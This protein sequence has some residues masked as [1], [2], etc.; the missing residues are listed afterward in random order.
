M[1]YRELGSANIEVSVV[2]MG[3]WAIVGDATWGPQ[4]EAESIATIQKAIES[5]MTVFFIQKSIVRSSVSTN[6]IP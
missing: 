6:N 3:C 5:G 2:A 1:R 4:E